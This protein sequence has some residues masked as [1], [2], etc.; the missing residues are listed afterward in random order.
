MSFPKLQI[1]ICFPHSPLFFQQWDKIE[2]LFISSLRKIQ[3]FNFDFYDKKTDLKI[4]IFFDANCFL[5][6]ESQ[7]IFIYFCLPQA[8]QHYIS[9]YV[10]YT[11]PYSFNRTTGWKFFLSAVLERSNH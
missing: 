1:Y 3:S 7:N 9:A 4:L 5:F 10:Y 8:L 6:E 11:S 2:I